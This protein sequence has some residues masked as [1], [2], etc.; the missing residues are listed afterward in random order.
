MTHPN[1]QLSDY[2]WWQTGII[3]QIY[4]LSF[5]DTSG[6]GQ[7]DLRGI[8]D[9]LD[10]VEWL[11]VTAIWLSPIHP[12]P[13]A[14]Y[15]YDISDYTDIDP[16]FGTLDDFDRLVTEA[17]DRGIRVI[18]DLVPNHTSDQ[19]PWFQASRSSRDNPKRDWYIWHDPAPN[20]GPPNNWL[21]AFGGSAWAWDAATEQYYYH[22]F[23]R[24][25]PDLN[26][27]NPAVVVAM[28]DVMRFWLDRG[29]DGFRVDVIWHLIKDEE[30]RDN[31]PNPDYTGAPHAYD[32]LLPAYTTD[33]P[34]VHNIVT[35]MR[36]VM[37]E[38]EDR[39]LIGEIYLPVGQ[40]V[41]Y[42]GREDAGL[43]LP[44][45]F[46][47]VTQPWD[48][49]VIA[50]GMNEYVGALPDN[51]WPNWV[52]G[53]HDISRI[54][55]RVGPRQARVAAMLLLTAWGTPTIYYGDEIGMQDV[56]IPAAELKD[57]GGERPLS[58]SRDPERTPMQWRDAPRAG[59]TTG[60]PWLPVADNYAT[61]NVEVEQQD[62]KSMLALYRRL[63]ELRQSEPALMVGNF[64]LV[65]AAGDLL[66]YRSGSKTRHF[67]TILN[68]RHAAAGFTLEG[69]G[70]EI[71]VS[72]YLDREGEAVSGNLTLRAD[73]GVV[74]R[75]NE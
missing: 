47:L 69:A 27:R 16:T 67:L 11:G 48:A 33:Q 46:M 72:T 5:Q 59:F 75:L 17:H 74:L 35:K 31:P 64:A 63:I 22:A 36:R 60:T 58:S 43:H 65:P 14:D 3:Y 25:Q 45:N 71:A 26:W 28:L 53:N 56:E 57:T 52:L 51:G 41:T 21:S 15:G 6:D 23:L 61:A 42:Y 20:G 13:M 68:L 1:R 44:F 8:I 32:A 18:L 30:F 24:E 4:P 7:G 37:D 2:A 9:R 38:Y 66:A 50:A 54:V 62:P 73:E 55:S 29:V 49:S 19:H 12:S 70:G 34:E 39:L 10:Y 40:L